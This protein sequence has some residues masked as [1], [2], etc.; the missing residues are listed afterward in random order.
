MSIE[1]AHRSRP[2]TPPPGKYFGPPKQDKF[3]YPPCLTQLTKTPEDDPGGNV[4]P[5]FREQPLRVG[6]SSGEHVMQSTVASAEPHVSKTP[7]FDHSNIKLNHARNMPRQTEKSRSKLWMSR[8][9]SQDL[10]VN[11]EVLLKERLCAIGKRRLC[12]GRR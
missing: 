7:L 8:T 4:T 6:S 12:L 2:R 1:K 11:D 5:V 9:I 10:T 3:S